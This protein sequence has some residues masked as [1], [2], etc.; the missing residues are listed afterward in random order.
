[1]RTNKDTLVVSFAKVPPAPP[2]PSGQPANLGQAAKTAQDNVTR[3]ILQRLIA[4]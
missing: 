1:M 2:K 4:P 3:M